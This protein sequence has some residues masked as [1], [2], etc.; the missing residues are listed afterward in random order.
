M[1][2]IS[3]ENLTI[4]QRCGCVWNYVI[5]KTSHNLYGGGYC[6]CPACGEEHEIKD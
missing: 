4:C 6:V 2:Q 1:K 3:L 5:G